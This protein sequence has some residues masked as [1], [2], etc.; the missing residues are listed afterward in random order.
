M[1]TALFF[2]LAGL[3]LAQQSR[4]IVIAH[5]G[6][7]GYLPEHT[8]EAK[9]LAYGMGADYLEQDIVLSKDG[10]P[11]VLHDIQIDT[12]T[13]VAKIF[14]ERK[15]AN[16]HYYAIDFTVAEIKRLRVS[17]RFD[18]KTGQAVFP[19]RFPLG[20]STFVVSTLEEELQ[21]IQGLNRSTGRNVGVYPEIKS[22]A[23]HRRQGQDAASITM[24]L[25]ARYGYATKADRFFLQC[26]EFEEVKRIR[27]ELGF[28]GKLVQLVGRYGGGETDGTLGATEDV[29][30]NG[31]L[32]TREGLFDVA[33]FADGVGPSYA[34][35]VAAA[36]DGTAKVNDVVRLAHEAKLLVHP[37]TVRADSLPKYAATTEKLLEILYRQAGVDGVFIDQPDL[38]VK[39]LGGR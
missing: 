38:A 24:K 26:F 17:E 6:A 15:R 18:P 23:W 10:V 7:S 11:L 2:A 20:Q 16:G 13:D 39:F 3:A 19:K 21:L 22:P 36:P 30:D 14:P 35:L 9:A 34:L 1:K 5:R 32:L 27:T 25:L 31:K 33:K 37:Y 12:V 8:L 28:Q 4:P 29:R